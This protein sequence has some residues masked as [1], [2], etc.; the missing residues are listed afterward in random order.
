MSEP[1]RLLL[2]TAVFV[3]ALG[4][5]LGWSLVQGDGGREMSFAS[6]DDSPATECRYLNPVLRCRERLSI[7]VEAPDALRADAIA[8]VEEALWRMEA[9]AAVRQLTIDWLTGWKVLA[10][11]PA[12]A[13]PSAGGRR[14][15]E[16]ASEHALFVYV[17]RN[18]GFDVPA[19]KPARRF[20][21]EYMCFGD[22]CEGVTTGIRIWSLDANHV[23]KVLRTTLG[24]SVLAQPPSATTP[25]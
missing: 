7:C 13:T 6:R 12:S 1:R 15:V 24:L 14:L 9:E 21:P 8:A 10:G 25:P 5:L 16:V 2:L 22:A 4:G 19:P 23:H 3:T 17:S 20:E 11:C 18:A